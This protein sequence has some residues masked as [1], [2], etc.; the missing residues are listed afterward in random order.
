MTSAALDNLVRAGLLK[1]EAGDRREIE[2][3]LESGRRRLADADRPS[4]SAESRFDLAY[5]AAHAL[6]LAAMRWHG[7]RPDRRR[8]VVFQALVHTLDMKPETA[9]ILDKCHA[10]RNLAEYEGAFDIDMQLL[11][12][13]LAAAKDVQ[14]AV[15]AL[16]RNT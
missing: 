8:F 16:I 1:R 10:R 4:L 9:R 6:A 15:E 12:D 13:L 7:Y 11:T 5:N 2:G 3:L 14:A